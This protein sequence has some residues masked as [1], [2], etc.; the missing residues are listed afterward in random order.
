MK[1]NFEGYIFCLS[2]WDATGHNNETN[3]CV[4][5]YIYFVRS[6]NFKVKNVAHIYICNKRKK[7]IR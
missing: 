5:I 4:Y 3:V 6:I 7:M 1:F 2:T